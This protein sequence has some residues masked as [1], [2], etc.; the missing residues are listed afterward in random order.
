M[1]RRSAVMQTGLLDDD[2][3]IYSEEIDLCQ[4]LV[5]AGW[6]LA[7][8]PQAQV[9]HFGG[10]STRQ[11]AAAMFIRLYQGKILFFRKNGGSLQATV[12]KWVLA[13]S[14]LPRLLLALLA[15]FLPAQRRLKAQGRA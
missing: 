2:Y 15:P 3:F 11:V 13:V 5:R 10:Q 14:A 6:R 7:W 8:V 1:L 4:R 12:Y 9:I